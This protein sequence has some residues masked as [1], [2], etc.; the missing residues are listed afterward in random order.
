M[1]YSQST[2]YQAISEFLIGNPEF[3]EWF[4]KYPIGF[5]LNHNTDSNP[6][7]KYNLLKH[8]VYTII[9]QAISWVKLGQRMMNAIEQRIPGDNWKPEDILNLTDEDF[10]LMM[11]SKNKMQYARAAAQFIFDNPSLSQNLTKMTSK[12]IVDF[13]IDPKTKKPKIPGVSYYTIKYHLY[14]IGRPDIAVY[15]DMCVREGI[16]YVYFTPESPRP[17]IAQCSKICENWGPNA[18]IGTAMCY[19]I[20]NKR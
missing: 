5:A 18:S 11:F 15:E 19:V 8:I 3:I 2:Q 12:E 13:F 6:T 7:R 16:K 9:S 10:R 4:H 1:D 17:T 20:Y 14:D